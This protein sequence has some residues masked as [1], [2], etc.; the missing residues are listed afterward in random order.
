[1]M[2]RSTFLVLASIP[3]LAGCWIVIGE[4]FNGYGVAPSDAGTGGDSGSD[5]GSDAT[6][7]GAG[8]SAVASC[9]PA[10][11]GANMVC[12]PADNKCKLDGTTSKVGAPCDTQGNA[13]PKCGA[14]SNRYCYETGLDGFPG[15]YCTLKPCDDMVL[16]PVGATCAIFSGESGENACYKI[17]VTGND[18]RMLEGYGCYELDRFYK[19]GA[20]TK[21]CHPNAFMCSSSSNCPPAKP[22]CGDAGLCVN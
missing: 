1:M 11:T 22:T 2:K 14:S 7:D 4:S 6:N 15:G 8:D 3:M 18:C 9:T 13:D 19:S 17:C 5:A 10:C 12:D 16:C 21:V 20:S